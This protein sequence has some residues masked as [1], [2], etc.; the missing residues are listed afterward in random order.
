MSTTIDSATLARVSGTPTAQPKQSAEL[1]DNFM[2]LLI[3]QLKNQD[4]LNP[5]ENHEMTSQLAQINTVNG[6]EELNETLEGITG[7]IEANRTLQAASLI[8]QG[9]LVPGDRVL[10]EQDG[11][12]Q[13]HTTPFGV[14][15]NQ[16][17]SNLRITI[18]ASDGTT[19]NRYDLGPAQA[20]VQSFSWDGRT[21]QGEQAASGAYRVRIESLQGQEATSVPTLNYAQ[22]GGVTPTQDGNVKLDLGA[23]YGQVDIQDIKQIL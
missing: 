6:I 8:G 13:S 7:Q 10:V 12:G 21:Q 23:I 19:I 22:V 3:T 5:L 11:E 20:G 14:M 17:A 9:V 2:E 1:R 15:L 16:P 18:S 4:P